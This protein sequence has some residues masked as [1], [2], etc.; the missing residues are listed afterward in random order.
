MI[1]SISLSIFLCIV[2]LFLLILFCCRKCK[3]KLLKFFTCSERIVNGEAITPA[4]A[5]HYVNA[6]KQLIRN[7]G[8]SQSSKAVL[9]FS[10][11]ELF[12]SRGFVTIEV[13]IFKERL[14]KII[15]YE[16]L[17]HCSMH[18]DEDELKLVWPCQ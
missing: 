18:V 1:C 5:D 10:L 17:L 12:A 16:C 3:G 11:Q 9:L 8:Y 7:A 6:V 14:N 4:A 13:P 2:L 15:T